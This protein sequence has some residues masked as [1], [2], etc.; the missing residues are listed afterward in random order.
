LLTDDVMS[1]MSRIHRRRRSRLG[2]AALIA[3]SLLAACGPSGPPSPDS[4]DGARADGI[5]S[6]SIGPSKAVGGDKFQPWTDGQMA[7]FVSGGQGFPMLVVRVDVAGPSPPSCLL[8]QTVVKASNY[9]GPGGEQVGHDSV[10]RKT[11]AQPD[12][13]RATDDIY[14]VVDY[15]YNQGYEITT[16]VGSMTVTR[17][18]GM[19][20]L[21]LRDLSATAQDMAAAPDLADHD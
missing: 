7:H 15:D 16:T 5:T 20:P 19:A 14:V 10:P 21:P 12:G 6:L 2:Y 18:L 9:Y 4:C 1:C 17:Q 3:M 13:S 8:Q 11:Y